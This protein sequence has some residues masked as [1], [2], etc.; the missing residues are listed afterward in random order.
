MNSDI[1]KE[2]EDSVNR[3][4]RASDISRKEFGSAV[5]KKAARWFQ[6]K[7]SEF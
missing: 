5:S 7:I 6:A 1:R 4:V 3:S 2:V